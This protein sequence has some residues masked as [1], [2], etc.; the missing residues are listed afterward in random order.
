MA[1]A[2]CSQSADKSVMTFTRNVDGGSE[3]HPLKLNGSKTQFI[4]AYS[5]DGNTAAL[6]QHDSNTRGAK[7]V[8]LKT[9]TALTSPSPSSVGTSPS[10][11]TSGTSLSFDSKYSMSYATSSD[12]TSVTF[13]LTLSG[14]RSWMALGI[15]P[16]G[17]MT[18]GGS[19]SRRCYLF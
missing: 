10:L 12:S 17:K 2:T 14:G 6:A 13:T 16:N 19:G 15:S 4:W 11:A 3:K 5:A 7:G 18:N 1:G 8:D 9:G